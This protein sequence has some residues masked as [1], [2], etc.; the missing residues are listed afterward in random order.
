MKKLGPQEIKRLTQGCQSFKGLDFLTLKSVIFP[1]SRLS[2]SPL[3]CG[4][5]DSQLHRC[6]YTMDL[7]TGV[8]SSLPSDVIGPLNLCSYRRNKFVWIWWYGVQPSL[9]TLLEGMQIVWTST[10]SWYLWFW[11]PKL[12]TRVP[13]LILPIQKEIKPSQPLRTKNVQNRIPW[14]GLNSY[15]LLRVHLS[16]PEFWTAHSI[17]L[18]SSN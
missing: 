7:L 2:H 15:L 3:C 8:I 10:H 12:L 11:M 13:H 6:K 1:V 5:K 14:W 18:Y 16:N 4:P 17:F 9:K